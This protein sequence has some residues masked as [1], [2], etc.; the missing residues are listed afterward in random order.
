[1]SYLR[2]YC[3]TKKKQEMK[4]ET[5]MTI[6]KN[7]KPIK[8][9]IYDRSEDELIAT[10]TSGDEAR[11]ALDTFLNRL[12]P[13]EL[14]DLIARGNLFVFEAKEIQLRIK[15]PERNVTYSLDIN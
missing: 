14:E 2:Q 7:L 13:E 8:Y 9:L 3:Q 12:S 15:I 5:I 11:K 4:T 6:N 1:M 10:C